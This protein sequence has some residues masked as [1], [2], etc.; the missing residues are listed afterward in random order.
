LR[1]AIEIAIVSKRETDLVGWYRFGAILGVIFTEV[2]LEC[3]LPINEILRTKM[4][5]A[6]LKHLGRERA[7]RI[8]ISTHIFP[9]SLDKDA[10]GWTADSKLYPDLKRKGSRKRMPVSSTA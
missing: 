9:E 8:A 7:S 4:E 2:T 10:S 5:T 6:F 1:Q 3:D